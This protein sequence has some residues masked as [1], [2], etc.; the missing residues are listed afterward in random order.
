MSSV[1]LADAQ[2]I[3]IPE[4]KTHFIELFSKQSRGETLETRDQQALEFLVF[5]IESKKKLI[6]GQAELEAS[7]QRLEASQAQHEAM[8]ARLVRRVEPDIEVFTIPISDVED[9][10]D[11]SR[12]CCMLG[13]ACAVI[14]AVGVALLVLNCMFILSA[15]LMTLSCAMIVKG[16]LGLGLVYWVECC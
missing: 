2:F 1:T 14:V 5:R 8:R 10:V 6:T 12:S 16:G 4:H 3:E 9:D 7:F 13:V 11:A 15:A